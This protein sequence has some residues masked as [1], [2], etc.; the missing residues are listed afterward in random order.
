MHAVLVIPGIMGTRLVLPGK[1]G[2]DD[3]EVWPPTPAE[4]QFGYAR[5]E[6]LA[7]RSVEPREIISQVLCFDFYRPLVDLLADL[8]FTDTGTEKRLVPFPYDWRR[9]LFDTASA[10]A[11][12]LDAVHADGATRITLVVHSMGGLIARLLL[13]GPDW[14]GRP[15]FGAIEQL[16][17]IA[18]PHLGAPL[19]LGRV[20]GADSAM[21]ISGPDFAWLASCED[22]PSAYQLLP[23]PG[24]GACWDQAD[25]G[26]APLD[27]Y[28]PEVATSLGLNPTLIARARAVHATLGAAPAHV[29]YFYFAGAGHRTATRV[30]V[31]RDAA[32]AILPEQTMLTRT[33]DAGDGTVPM[34][35]AL[36]RNGQRH[37]ATNEHATAFK[38]EPFRRVFVRLLGGDEGPAE[39]VELAAGL[40]LSVEAPVVV[41]GEDVEVLLHASTEAEDTFGALPSVEGELILWRLNEDAAA[42]IERRTP[43]AYR[44]PPLE[45]LRLYLEPIAAPGHFRLTFEGSPSDAI[46]AV[47]GV[48]TRLPAAVV[49]SR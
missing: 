1:D 28:R 21:G 13:E 7:H 17:A 33:A 4:T 46:P 24:E 35:S 26:L 44:G 16:V 41:A 19:A 36:P 49:P 30:N 48:C 47:F 32:G 11:A 43:I 23:A 3:E 20:L 39:E 22:Y 38:G 25:P 8:G 31:Y 10:L 29:R 14:R 27:I 34:F 5:R 9:D 37:V 40:A 45:R 6:K 2:A 15:W 12:K 18:V 42:T